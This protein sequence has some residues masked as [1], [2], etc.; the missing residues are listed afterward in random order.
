MRAYASCIYECRS[1]EITAKKKKKQ[2]NKE[3]ELE[4]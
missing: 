3:N 4:K 2:R 1:S